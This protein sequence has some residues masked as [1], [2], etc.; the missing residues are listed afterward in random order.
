MTSLHADEA[1]L[2]HYQLNHDPFA[3]RVPG[4]KFF[5]AQR[6]PVLGQLHHLAR[7]SQLLLVVTGPQGSGKTLLRQALVAS[8]NKQTVQSVVISARGASDA[9]A[10]LAQAAQSLNVAKAEVPAILSQVVQLGL[11]G[12][13]VYLLVDDAEQ[14]GES[15]LQ[16][17]LE[18]AAGT[19][20]GRPHVFL[21]GEPSLI[22]SLDGLEI[23]E[24]RFHVIELQ[25]YSEDETREY[26]EQRLEGAGRG[27]E[28]FTAEQIADIQQNSEGWPG[29]INQVARDT[30][31]EAM[32]AS[33]STVKRPSVGFS[34]P[35][36]HVL[37]LS[38]VV[39]VAVGAA[40]LM[41][42]KGDQPKTGAPAEQ[43]QLPLG[44]GQPGN[45]QSNNGGPAIEFAGSSQPMPLPLVGQSQPVMRG[46][47]AEAAGMNEGEEGG[48]AGNTA[49][50]PPT[51]TT[52]APPEGA[53]AGP[54]PTPA[55]PIQP[56]QTLA[57]AQPVAPV[58]QP[59]AP[60]A[61]KPVAP[62]PKPAEVAVAKP[63][64]PAAK[65]VEK[66]AAKPA[67]APAGGS[68]GGGWY[69]AQAPGN[70]VVQIL[71]TSSEATAQAYVK[72]Q[73]GDYRYFKKN[74]QGKPLYV[75]TYGS[76]SS[77]DAALNAIKALPAKVQAGKPWPRTVAS[78]QQ[79]LAAT[80]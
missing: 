42:K 65:P 59:A 22:A 2:G 45:A 24:E 10:V 7:Y 56:A 72:A 11:T 80:R 52:T 53:T 17:L 70:Y 68:T 32:I 13:E 12:Q 61:S 14:L 62:A 51:V 48:P 19:A 79:E 21:F 55:Q 9:A 26:L 33:R 31:I 6:K 69:A 41:P 18:L 46:P 77:R 25:P 37:A 35:K 8:T 67:A 4:F 60:V 44:Q 36:K 1:F 23:E 54:A 5:P 15:A 43:A 49:L 63:V 47:L 20:E 16:A 34:M 27:I 58:H 50:Q 74:L 40:V 38:A 30:L 39:I 64:A 3:A 29:N 76:F 73:G 71:G 28:V 57:S 75:I 78:V 66:P